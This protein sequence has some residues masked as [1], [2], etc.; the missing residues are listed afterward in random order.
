MKRLIA[1]AVLAGVAIGGITGAGLALG[2]ERKAKPPIDVAATAR[3]LAIT[4]PVVDWQEP[5]APAG[6]RLGRFKLTYYWMPTESGGGRRVQL[7]N[8]KTC[9]PVAKVSASFARKLRLEGGGKLRDGRVL[10]YSGACRCPNSPCY[11]IARRGHTWGTGVRERPLSPFRSVAVDPAHVSIGKTLYI[12][13][14]DGMT[15]P[16]AAPWGGFVHDGCVVAD[17][18]GGGIRGRQLDLFA[19]RKSHYRAL[20][21]RHRLRKVTVF[22]GGERCQSLTVRPAAKRGAI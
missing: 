1:T 10:T 11:R 21:R 8:K 9:R 12:P 16:G 19:A 3:A 18:Q 22:D 20:D 7:Y 15:M 5:A 2:D 14:L 4:R 6:D 13:E 17:D